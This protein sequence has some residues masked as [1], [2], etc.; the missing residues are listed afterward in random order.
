MRDS[1][2]RWR[3]SL[4]HNTSFHPGAQILKKVSCCRYYGKRR[5]TNVSLVLD[6][7]LGQQLVLHD[8]TQRRIRLAQRS[9]SQSSWI[10]NFD[11]QSTRGFLRRLNV[12][13]LHTI[14]TAQH[15][16][17][18]TLT[19]PNTFHNLSSQASNVSKNSAPDASPSPLSIIL[20]APLASIVS[21]I[22][23]GMR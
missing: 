2:A 5:R 10:C 15:G 23:R 13:R 11:V 1:W 18:P 8:T 17:T 20:L 16:K 7:T 9:R 12:I 19:S 14:S 4:Q 21:S 3:D 22:K 6:S